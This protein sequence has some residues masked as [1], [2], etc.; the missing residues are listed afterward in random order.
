MAAAD[1]SGLKPGWGQWHGTKLYRTRDIN[2]LDLLAIPSTVRRWL[3]K[4]RSRRVE[5]ARPVSGMRKAPP[6]RLKATIVRTLTTPDEHVGWIPFV[7]AAGLRV[8]RQQ[9]VDVILVSSP[10]HS[11]QLAGLILAKL[12]RRPLVTDLRDPWQFNESAGFVTQSAWS[13]RWNAQLESKIVRSACY[14]VANTGTAEDVLRERYPLAA[15]KFRTITNGFDPVDFANIVPTRFSK[16]TL[17]HAGSFY[18]RRDPSCFLKGLAQWLARTRSKVRDQVQAFFIGDSGPAVASAVT[19]AGLDG[20]VTLVPHVPS[21]DLYPVLSGSDL[22]LLMLGSSAND[23]CVIPAKLYDY[24]AV[25]RPIMAFVPEDGEAA[26]LLAKSRDHF[27]LT[28]ED[29]DRV[30]E[31]LESLY[32]KWCDSA[33]K[34]ARQMAVDAWPLFWRSHLAEQLRDVLTEAADSAG[35]RKSGGNT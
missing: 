24:L 21:A 13:D 35:W 19:E 17:T 18:G 1:G 22:L 6:G 5:S 3:N 4:L 29:P 8:A 20:V 30:T 9:R 33:Q 11:S 26:R 16:F 34:G 28:T 7:I 27:V 23:R 10:P 12:L 32:R 15:E 2:S 25:G 14:V 31:I